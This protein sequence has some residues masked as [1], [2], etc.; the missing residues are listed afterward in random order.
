MIP[1]VI[2]YCWFGGNPLP[3]IALKCINSWKEFFPDYEIKEWNESNFDLNC[4]DY[5]K[6]AYEAKKWAF[7]SDYARFW[8]LYNYGGLYFDT[9]VEVIKDMSDIIAK[10]PFMGCETSDKSGSSL[11]IVVNPGLGLGVI[12]GLSIYKEILENY[13]I[14]HF[15]N[16]DGSYNYMTVVDRTTNILKK[17]DFKEIDEIQMIANVYIYPKDYFCPM[18]YLTGKLNVT[19]NSRSIHWY[20]ASWLDDRMKKRR[21]KVESI[22]NYIHGT[23]GI[24]LSKAYMSCSYYW[25]WVSTG[26]FKTIKA[27]I[28]NRFQRNK[29]NL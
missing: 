3:D 1:K 13:N 10:G 9:D 28:S 24:I 17:Y 23:P 21:R 29:K 2:H 4:C 19:Q 26:D 6:E 5:V 16:Q 20:D 11:N 7:V 8:V 12:P 27:K 22:R 14:S 25:E 15:L 18:D